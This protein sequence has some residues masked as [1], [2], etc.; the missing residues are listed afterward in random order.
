MIRKILI[1]L[2]FPF[3]WGENINDL[4]YNSEN[5]ILKLQKGQDIISIVPNQIIY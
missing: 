2:V 5:Q 4:D 1:I 3:T